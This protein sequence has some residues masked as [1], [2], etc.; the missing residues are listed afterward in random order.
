MV[1]EMTDKRPSGLKNFTSETAPRNGR[2]KGSR[3]KL[4]ADFLYALQREF[5]QLGET[6]IRRVRVDH[7]VDFL[8]VIASV[9]PKE[10]EITD[11]RLKDVPDE[12]LDAIVEYIN[13]RLASSSGHGGGREGSS[14]N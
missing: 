1:A 4:G 2:M 7:P 5:E 8:K 11:S 14:L 6:V 12:Q 9:L 10:L 3:N 13:G